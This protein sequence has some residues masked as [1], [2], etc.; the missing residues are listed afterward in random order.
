[1][2]NFNILQ[3]IKTKKVT[4]ISDIEKVIK[5]SCGKGEM[6]L[7]LIHVNPISGKVILRYDRCSDSFCQ[8][9]SRGLHKF[10]S[11]VIKK[12]ALGE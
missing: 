10:T 2:T 12:L 5:C 1:M 3:E 9:F 4:K 7:K 11:I 8:D 6:K